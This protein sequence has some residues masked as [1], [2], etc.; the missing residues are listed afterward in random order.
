MVAGRA[1]SPA[2]TGAGDRRALVC[3]K[4]LRRER[5]VCL[6][7]TRFDSERLREPKKPHR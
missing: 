2:M 4:T 7:E 5:P 3:G 1:T 6:M